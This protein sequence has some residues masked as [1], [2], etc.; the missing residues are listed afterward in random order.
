MQK[1]KPDKASTYV[2]WRSIERYIGREISEHWKFHRQNYRV[3]E[4]LELNHWWRY[5]QSGGAPLVDMVLNTYIRDRLVDDRAFFAFSVNSLLYLRRKSCYRTSV[6]ASFMIAFDTPVPWRWKNVQEDRSRKLFSQNRSLF[7]VYDLSRNIF[8]SFCSLSYL[9]LKIL[10]RS[11]IAV[12][13]CNYLIFE[14]ERQIERE[15]LTNSIIVYP[16]L[17]SRVLLTAVKSSKE[18]S[19][20]SI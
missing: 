2:K 20:A 13:P 12:I 3:V 5:L 18:I 6:L 4:H 15:F 10:G 1:D 7:L 14:I 19:L 8:P 11:S 17:Y 16:P 9:Y